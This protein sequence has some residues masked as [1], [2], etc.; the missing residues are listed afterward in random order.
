LLFT[1]KRAKAQLRNGPK[2]GSEEVRPPTA[3]SLPAVKRRDFGSPRLRATIVGQVCQRQRQLSQRCALTGAALRHGLPFDAK[4][5]RQTDAQDSVW[6]LSFWKGVCR[7]YQCERQAPNS[8]VDPISAY[9]NSAVER[10]DSQNKLN[11]IRC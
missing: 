11:A 4:I 6:P 3:L 7:Q 9:V 10:K 2:T 8:I 1:R 5:V